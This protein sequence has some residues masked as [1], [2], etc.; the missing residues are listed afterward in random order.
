MVKGQEMELALGLPVYV[1]SFL[2]GKPR[3]CYPYTLENINKFLI[4][5]QFIDNHEWNDLDNDGTI[6]LYC[7]LTES[8]RDSESDELLKNIGQDNFV[9]VIQDIKYISGIKS[10]NSKKQKKND[11]LSW[12]RSINIIQA[13]TGNT[14]KDI[15]QMT[16]RQFYSL[17]EYV[18]VVVNW[19][20]K[21][22]LWS[23]IK[24][25]KKFL[26]D[27]EHPMAS[28]MHNIQGKKRMTMSDLNDFLGG[29]K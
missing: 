17:L 8:F 1:T 25:K 18:G 12:E 2:D 23:E 15:K 4:Y 3:L 16:L 10:N 28:D 6:A 9:E 5:L 24:D 27:S 7:I 26:S 21:I 22:A 20:Y 13:Y 29:T 19:N 11:A 14:L